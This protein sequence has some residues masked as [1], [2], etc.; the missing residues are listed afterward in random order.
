ML[1]RALTTVMLVGLVLGGALATTAVA[2][3]GGGAHRLPYEE[4]V[5]RAGEAGGEFLPPEYERPG[6]FD[7]IVYPLVGAGVVI[8]GM[9]L[10]RYLIAQPRFSREAE[11]RSRR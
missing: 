8:T 10:F 2:V 1:K 3:E 5:E 7:W 6:F 11:Q 4:I 9:V